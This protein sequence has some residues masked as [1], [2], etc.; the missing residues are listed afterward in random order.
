[1]K[2]KE[3]VMGGDMCGEEIRGSKKAEKNCAR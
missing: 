2:R 3:K 1:M